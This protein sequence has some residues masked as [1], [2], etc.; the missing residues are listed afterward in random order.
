MAA[1]GGAERHLE[2][3]SAGKESLGEADS[4]GGDGCRRLNGHV[5]DKI[6]DVDIPMGV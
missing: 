5:G 2:T 1:R 6:F 3:Y 4:G